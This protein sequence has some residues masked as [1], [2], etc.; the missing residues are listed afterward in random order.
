VV[1]TGYF[2]IHLKIGYF[3]RSAARTVKH[4]GIGY[5][6]RFE[7]RRAFL[8]RYQVQQAGGR[9]ILEYWIPA[10]D[11][12]EFNVNIVGLIEVSAEYQRD[13]AAPGAEAD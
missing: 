4:S 6:T 13:S 10:E 3:H 5:V 11:L 9:T 2:T 12:A 7:V 8:D 1:A